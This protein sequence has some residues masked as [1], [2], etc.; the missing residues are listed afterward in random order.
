MI[1]WAIIIIFF[2]QKNLL[3]SE[4]KDI[5]LIR[6]L[7]KFSNVNE[8]FSPVNSCLEEDKNKTKVESNLL[9]C[10][11]EGTEKISRLDEN[12]DIIREV[13][14]PKDHSFLPPGKSI[15][16]FKNPFSLDK[17]KEFK[18]R[19]VGLDFVVLNDDHA[20]NFIPSLN[21][22]DVGNTFGLGGGI[23]LTFSET[24]PSKKNPLEITLDLT[25]NLSLF[26]AELGQTYYERK[27]SG[28][29]K[30]V[31][32]FEEGTNKTRFSLQYLSTNEDDKKYVGDPFKDNPS[33]AG[34]FR[35]NQSA[36]TVKRTS[37]D[38]SISK[39][40]SPIIGNVDLG[41]TQLNDTKNQ[42]GTAIQNDWH[43]LNN[44]Y[45]YNWWDYSNLIIDGIQNYL[46]ISSQIGLKTEAKRGKC[47]FKGSIT[48]GVRVNV[49]LQDKNNELGKINF[50]IESKNES[51]IKISED[52]KKGHEFNLIGSVNASLDPQNPF[53]R[54]S[55]AGSV[56]YVQ[57]G[58]SLEYVILNKNEEKSNQKK[59]SVKV[60]FFE[61]AVPIYVKGAGNN[62]LNRVP[63]YNSEGKKTNLWNNRDRQSTW[64]KLT[65]KMSL[66]K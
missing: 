66:S 7:N 45:V 2:L 37:A 33:L 43:E 32:N 42:K 12:G 1:S 64:I 28:Y 55:E 31:A 40:E 35:Y 20:N 39:K 25:H 65:F 30:R 21:S 17:K 60:T 50:L 18:L 48:S 54:L 23:T 6:S 61:F 44:I 22:D 36:V 63:K 52:K 62:L 47:E 26:T 9:D 4:I 41:L 14:I 58:L 24:N 16:R 53:P 59:G 8:S 34:V 13:T 15:I 49:P 3:A 11:I 46:N 57:P 5:E 56:G 51:K 10:E 19:D 27:G 38:L 29:D